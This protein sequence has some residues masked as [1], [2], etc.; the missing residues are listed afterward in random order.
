MKLWLLGI[1]FKIKVL[2]LFTK[3]KQ[4]DY[5]DYKKVDFSLQRRTALLPPTLPSPAVEHQTEKQVLK[6]T[7]RQR[8]AS[9]NF[10]VSISVFDNNLGQVTEG[11]IPSPSIF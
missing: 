9:P 1:T 7:W 4:E 8:V 5:S 11:N 10:S 6:M 3:Q 2:T